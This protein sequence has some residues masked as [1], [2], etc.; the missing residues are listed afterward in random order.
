MRKLLLLGPIALLVVMLLSIS[1]PAKS[2][3]SDDWDLFDTTERDNRVRHQQAMQQQRQNSL[4]IGAAVIV[5]A[6]IVGGAIVYRRK[7]E[8]L[9]TSSRESSQRHEDIKP[10]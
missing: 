3:L 9:P 5:A 10:S 7:S 2:I 1:A 8:R 4:M 6:A